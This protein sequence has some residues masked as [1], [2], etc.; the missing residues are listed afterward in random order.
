MSLLKLIKEKGYKYGDVVLSSGKT[1]MHYVNCKPVSLSNEGIKLI[2]QLML[3][4]VDED[5][6]AVA[7]VTLGGDPL[8][9]GVSIMSGKLDAM[10]VRKD[11]KGYGTQ[12]MIEGPTHPIGSVVTLLED[13]VTTGGSAIKAVKIL[14]EAGYVVNKVVCIVDRGESDKIFEENKV[15]LCSIYTLDDLL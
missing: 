7:G 9:T 15:E 13:V 11:P 4:H 5:A 12:A 1:S 10:L 6:V 3:P 2:S 8:A 14:R